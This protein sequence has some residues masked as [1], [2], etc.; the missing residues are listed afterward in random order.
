MELLLFS[1]NSQD[2]M[3]YLRSIER[4]AFYNGPLVILTSK[5]SASASEI[6]AAALQDYG[7]A[8]I[9]GDETT[10]GKGSIQ[11]QTV[12]D[13]TADYFFKVTVGKYYTVSGKTTQ[14]NGVRADIVVPSNYSAYKIGEKYLQFPLKADK[15][16]DAYNDKL[17]DIDRKIKAWFKHNYLPYLQKKVS[18]WQKLS[19]K[20]KR[21][22]K[23]RIA[24]DP[25]F[26]NFLKKQKD[27]EAKLN[28]EDIEIQF[29]DFGKEDLQLQEATNILKDM[30]FIEADMRKA[31]GL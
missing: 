6:V 17:S 2:E 15:V 1:K 31:S 8:I 23:N 7:V 21:N 29:E 19:P 10:F 18:F 22:S 25:N 30:I 11:Y 16:K 3:R 9:V 13:K 5:L 4:E 12:T 27:L 20:L 24:K 14:I 28:G 26:Q